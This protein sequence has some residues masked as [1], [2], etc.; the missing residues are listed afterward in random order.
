MSGDIPSFLG[1]LPNL[2]LCWLR[3]NIFE[4]TVPSF[5]ENAGS[6]QRLIFDEN[7]LHGPAHEVFLTAPPSNLLAVTLD[8]NMLTGYIPSEVGLFSSL[9]FLDYFSNDLTGILPTELGLLLNW[10]LCR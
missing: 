1:S 7:R 9:T 5:A 2:A 8:D 6:L 3:D 10:K 4:D